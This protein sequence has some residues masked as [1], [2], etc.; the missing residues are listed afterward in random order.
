VAFRTSRRRLV[1]LVTAAMVTAG[2]GLPAESGP[3]WTLDQ[4]GRTYTY[5]LTLSSK[6]AQDVVLD[7]LFDPRHVA[8]FSKSAGRLVVLKEDGPVNEIRFDTR[9]LIFKCSTTFQRTLVRDSGAI[10]I[11]MTGFKAGWGKLAP[12]ARS[13]R[14]RYT[15]TDRGTHR[16]IVYC[17][18]V[19]TD[20]PVSGY[21]LRVLR[22]SMGEFANDLDQ[23]LQRT[24]LAAEKGEAPGIAG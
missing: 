17:Q 10:E 24:D 14:A 7:V 9:R 21:S 11:E 5:T 3:A 20:K 18:D 2:A 19:E 13:S 1:A 8:A 12:H 22:K 23:Y 6:L 4:S 16:E 15:V